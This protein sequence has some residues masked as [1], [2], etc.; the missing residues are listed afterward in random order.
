MVLNLSITCPERAAPG[1]HRRV[2]RRSASAATCSCPHATAAKIRATA[3]AQGASGLLI[4]VWMSGFRFDA[5]NCACACKWRGMSAGAVRQ[6]AGGGGALVL[7]RSSSWVQEK[8]ASHRLCDH[9]AHAQGMQAAQRRVCQ[10][11]ERQHRH[12]ASAAAA[13]ECA[14]PG[15]WSMPCCPSQTQGIHYARA[16]GM[17]G[18]WRLPSSREAAE[19]AA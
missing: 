8:F 3:P 17:Q 10:A 18:S 5:R 4:R 14:A 9:C 16:L 15:V 7:V 2:S 12:Q 6:L 13:A 11:A 19:A 1:A